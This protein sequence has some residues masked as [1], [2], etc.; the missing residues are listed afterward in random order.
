[1]ELTKIGMGL[2]C[3]KLKNPTACND[4]TLMMR[5]ELIFADFIPISPFCLGS[6]SHPTP[7]PLTKI[8]QRAD[9]FTLGP[10]ASQIT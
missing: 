3:L 5:I 8:S 10:L 9:F 7:W 4:G 2:T 6:F 1:M